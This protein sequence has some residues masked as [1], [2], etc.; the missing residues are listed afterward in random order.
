M[1][2]ND[3][4][5]G[6]IVFERQKNP[7]KKPVEVVLDNKVL[8]YCIHRQQVFKRQRKY[9]LGVLKPLSYPQAAICISKY[10][11]NDPLCRVP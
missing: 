5:K 7:V 4:E 1:L 9:H 10:F 8:F 2:V 6:N 3:I 11:L